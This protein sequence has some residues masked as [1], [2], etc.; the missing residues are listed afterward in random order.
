MFPSGSLMISEL[1]HSHLSERGGRRRCNDCPAIDIH[2][3]HHRELIERPGGCISWRWNRMGNALCNIDLVLYPDHV[4]LTD[5][6]DRSRLRSI[7]IPLLRTPCRYGGTRPWFECPNCSQRCAKLYFCDGSFR[8]RK[9]HGLGYMSQLA[10]RG[11]RPRLIAQCIRRKLGGSS[12]LSLPFPGKPPKMH[13]RTYGAIRA[14]GERVEGRAAKGL[15]EWLKRR[16]RISS[17]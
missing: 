15:L 7:S 5:V 11:D 13:W 9:C 1:G 4:V 8:C 16:P 14:R 10:A 6:T 12:N 2:H 3:P 17:A